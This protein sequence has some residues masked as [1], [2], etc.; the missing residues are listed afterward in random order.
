MWTTCSS[1][2]LLQMTMSSTKAKAARKSLMALSTCCWK[3]ALAFLRQ[4]GH[5]LVLEE[6]KGGCDD[7][8]CSQPP[9][10][11]NPAYRAEGRSLVLSPG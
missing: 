3:Y 2:L 9:W 11:R 6:A 8:L 10:W 5:H 1:W 7:G 4:K